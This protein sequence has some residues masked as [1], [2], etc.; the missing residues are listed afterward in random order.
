MSNAVRTCSPWRSRTRGRASTL[1]LS[2]SGRASGWAGTSTRVASRC[3]MPFPW[4]R[5][6]RYSNANCVRSSP[7]TR[8]REVM[9]LNLSE[10]EREVREWVRTFVRKEIIPLEPEVLSRERRGEP[11]LREV[12][13]KTIQDKAKESGFFG[14]HTPEEYGGMGLGAVMNAL[15]EVE[16]GRSFVQFKF[17][18]EADNILYFA[19]D[20]QKEKYLLPTISGERKSC[21]AITE[22]GAGSDAR[23]I[24]T[25]AICE[26]DEWVINGEKSFITGGNEADFTMVFAVTD[27]EKDADGGVTCFLVDRDHGWK[28]EYIDTM[29]EWGPAALII[30]N[31][32]VPHC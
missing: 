19:N 12:E 14:V 7:T 6:T 13:L 10:E 20:E 29:G 1:R 3:L 28:S 18:G 26:G 31:V 30:D 5:V 4:G 11:G 9:D 24:R 16:L 23:A 27:K 32:R 25:S 15:V 22:P 2:S 8:R 21:F 17:G